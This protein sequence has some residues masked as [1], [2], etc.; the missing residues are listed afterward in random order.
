MLAEREVID[1][2]TICTTEAVL[3]GYI[4]IVGAPLLE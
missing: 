1:W 2:Q 3:Y 4:H